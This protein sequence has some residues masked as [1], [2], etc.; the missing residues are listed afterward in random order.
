MSSSRNSKSRQSKRRK[1]RKQKRST[2]IER[3]KATYYRALELLSDLRRGVGTYS[4]LLRKHR[5][6]GRTARKYLGRDLIGGTRGTRV[7]A[8]KSDRRIRKVRFPTSSGDIFIITRNSKDATKLSEYFHD[9][10]LLL[11]NKL[12]AYDFEVKWRGIYV[13]GREVLADTNRILQMA[14]S[15]ELKIEHLYAGKGEER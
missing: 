10:E 9:R 7:R 12:R 5:L 3:D 11:G 1:R 6:R 15:G 14:D 13:A 2:R 8:S 4:A